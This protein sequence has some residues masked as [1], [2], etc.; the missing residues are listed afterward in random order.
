[1]NETELHEKSS[2][3]VERTRE[4]ICVVH[5]YRYARVILLPQLLNRAISSVNCISAS[6][7]EELS[8]I[9]LSV[10]SYTVNQQYHC[11]CTSTPTPSRPSQAPILTLLLLLYSTRARISKG[12]EAKYRFNSTVVIEDV[13]INVSCL[14]IIV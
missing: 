4:P 14:S 13:Q 3:S 12:S 2:P 1:M 5:T 7:E 10:L 9:V 11:W 8:S 6:P